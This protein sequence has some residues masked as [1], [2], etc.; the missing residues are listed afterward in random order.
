[1]MKDILLDKNGDLDLLNGDF[2]IG[3]SLLQ[4]VEILLQLNQGSLKSDPLCGMN[5]YQYLKGKGS[6]LELEKNL[7]IQLRRDGKNYK[8]IK[9]HLNLIYNNGQ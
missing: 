5:M 9:K 8:D 1:M 3:E 4:E 2:F 6:R 7:K